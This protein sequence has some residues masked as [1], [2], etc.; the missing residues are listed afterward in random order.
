[1]SSLTPVLPRDILR[2]VFEQAALDDKKDALKLV[3]VSRQVQ[4]WIELIIYSVVNLFHETTCRYFLRTI[5]TSRTKSRAFFTT[6]VKSLCV[7]HDLYN[8]RTVRIIS[9]CQGVTTLTFWAIPPASRAS[10]IRIPQEQIAAAL[11]PLRPQKLSALLHGVLG[12]PYPNFHLS[13]FQRISH[14]S[15]IDKWEDWTTWW[16]FEILPC[17]THLSFDFHVGPQS[18]D[19]DTAYTI[20]QAIHTVLSSCLHLRVCVLVLIFDPSPSFTAA[21][22]THHMPLSAKVD[23][24]LVF[25][26]NSEPFLEREAHTVR[27]ART[28]EVAEDAVDIQASGRDAEVLEI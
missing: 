28:W 7:S 3:L 27:E 17:L 25:V 15:V 1:M 11:D 16:G 21:K 10:I 20:A 19:D 2:L 18:L 14:L 5:E 6:H 23:S 26:G 4:H 12:S 24:R 13:F 9:A 22:I 8:N